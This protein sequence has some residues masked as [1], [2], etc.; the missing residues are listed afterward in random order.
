MM[1]AIK[2]FHNDCVSMLVDELGQK[3]VNSINESGITA[4][5]MAAA[6]GAHTMTH[7]RKASALSYICA[8]INEIISHVMYHALLTVYTSVDNIQK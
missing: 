6:T 7:K 2:K 5:H 3:A 8:H 1:L 4:A